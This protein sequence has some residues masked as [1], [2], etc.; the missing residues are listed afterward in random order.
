MRGR[1]AQKAHIPKW[2]DGVPEEHRAAVLAAINKA[3]SSST[4]TSAPAVPRTPEPSPHNAGFTQDAFR[5]SAR[6]HV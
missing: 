5:F 6:Q 1:K 3:S 2:V 4:S